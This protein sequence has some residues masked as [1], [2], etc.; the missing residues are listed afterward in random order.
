MLAHVVSVVDVTS[1]EAEDAVLR[2]YYEARAPHYDEAYA[3]EPPPWVDELIGDMRARL[4][5]CRVLEVA[6][7]TGVWTE[8]LAP[9][10]ESVTAIDASPAMLAIAAA[11]LAAHP[12]VQVRS[13]DAYQLGAVDGDFTGGLAMQWLSH[14]PLARM[15]EFLDGWHQRLGSGAQVFLGDNQLTADWEDDLIRKPGEADTYEPRLLPNGSEYVIVKNYFTE[16]QLR[17]LVEPA[18]EDVRITMGSR[19]WWLGYRVR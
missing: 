15:A 14:V 12:S 8:R 6:C 17:A 9:A 2:D 11:R 18:A 16:D 4:G 7:G 5:G 13:G 3:S 10:A 19:W 1:P